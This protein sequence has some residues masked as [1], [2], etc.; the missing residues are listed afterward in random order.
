PAIRG[1]IRRCHRIR[2]A[3]ER[4]IPVVVIFKLHRANMKDLEWAAEF[5]SEHGAAGLSVRTGSLSQDQ[6]ATAWMVV[7]FL[8]DLWRGRVAVGLE[9]PNRYS[10]PLETD[11]L[12]EWQSRLS[13]RTNSLSQVVSPLVIDSSGNVLP[14]RSEFPRTYSFGNLRRQTLR[15]MAG[16][17]IA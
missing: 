11:G 15:E 8:R 3:V 12:Y 2:M 7:E 17:W 5:A 14:L 16:P 1:R 13:T 9:A 4:G 6:L 10:V